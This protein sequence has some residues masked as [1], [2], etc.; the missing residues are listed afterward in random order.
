MRIGLLG[1]TFNPVHIGHLILAQE[2]WYQLDLDKVIF[3]PAFIPPHKQIPRDISAADRL[4]MVRLALE[5]DGRFEISTHEIDKS[6][7]S[8]SIDTIRYFLEKYS[9]SEL[10]FLTGADSAEGL[11]TWKEVEDIL[12]CV[13]FVIAARPGWEQNSPYEGS[14]QRIVMPGIELS[15]SV[16]REKIRKREPI[17]FFVPEKV[18]HYIR[19]KG[20]YRDQDHPLE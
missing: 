7:V 6:G 19:N 5:G 9:G 10:F 17:D 20:L 18:V 11:S 15:S 8:Y 2:C 12:K 1:G 16:I 13:T 3:I 14:I 4:N